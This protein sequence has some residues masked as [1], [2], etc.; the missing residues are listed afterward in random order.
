MPDELVLREH[1]RQ[2]LEQSKMPN[3]APDR[4]WGGPGV[5]APCTICSRAVSRDE[6]EFEVQFELD[7]GS[8]QMAVYHVHVRCFSAWELVRSKVDGHPPS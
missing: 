6:M 8:P 1:A 5:G 3:R 7:G 2:A 4:V